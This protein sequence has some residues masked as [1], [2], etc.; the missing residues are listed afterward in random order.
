M[1]ETESNV[2]AHLHVIFP[3]GASQPL[4]MPTCLANPPSWGHG[5]SIQVFW[6]QFIL[7]VT[8]SGSTVYLVLYPKLCNLRLDLSKVT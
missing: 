6:E 3:V 1:G 4:T 7:M 5:V 8:S 2:F